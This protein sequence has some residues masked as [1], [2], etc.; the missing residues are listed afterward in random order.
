MADEVA[1]HPSYLYVDPLPPFC[2]LFGLVICKDPLLSFGLVCRLKIDG[3]EFKIHQR[4]HGKTGCSSEKKASSG[5]V[6]TA[7]NL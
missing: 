3:G 7:I 5:E 6:T 2:F 4:F 1:M